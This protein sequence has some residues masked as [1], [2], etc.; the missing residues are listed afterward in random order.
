MEI[1]EGQGQ[2][3]RVIYIDLGAKREEAA[4]LEDAGLLPTA[5]DLYDEAFEAM[6]MELWEC[7]E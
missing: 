2:E 3:R 1:E 5:Q 6:A 7:W 4:I